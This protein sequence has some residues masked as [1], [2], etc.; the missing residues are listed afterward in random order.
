MTCYRGGNSERFV[1]MPPGGDVYMLFELLPLGGATA[2]TTAIPRIW[3]FDY[4]THL[5]KRLER[6]GGG[7]IFIQFSTGSLY[8]KTTYNHRICRSLITW[9]EN[10]NGRA[11]TLRFTGAKK[12]TLQKNVSV[13]CVQMTFDLCFHPDDTAHVKFVFRHEWSWMSLNDVPLAI[14]SKRWH[15][16]V[17][18]DVNFTF[19]KFFIL[20]WLIPKELVMKIM[21]YF[22]KYFDGSKDLV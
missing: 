11:A 10:T 9:H 4:Y 6:R 15:S 1:K 13:W 20:R 18:D 17:S 8:S 3:L 21:I 12:T 2:L 22:W 16:Y 14:L 19:P 5:F 7:G